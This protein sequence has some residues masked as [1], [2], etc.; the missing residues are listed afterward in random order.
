MCVPWTILLA[1]DSAKMREAEKPIL[2]QLV[3]KDGSKNDAP[4]RKRPRQQA[5]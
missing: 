5:D 2:D 1:G 4:R 3:D